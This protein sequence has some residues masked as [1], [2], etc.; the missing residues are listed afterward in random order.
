MVRG[1]FSFLEVNVYGAW[2]FFTLLLLLATLSPLP[3]QD[4]AT[5]SL[6]GEMDAVLNSN[7]VTWAEAARF[8]MPA[9]GMQ[10]EDVASAFEAARARG[11]LPKNAAP[12]T[13]ANFGGLSF[14]MMKAFDIP[15]GLMYRLFPGPHYA[16]RELVYRG[17]I[18]DQQDKSWRVSGF[19]LI[20]LIGRVLETSGLE[21]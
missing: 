5:A 7:A 1:L 21:E 18:Q 2:H 20:S 15:G 3:A 6:A 8:V 19:W 17:V 9:A 13:L 11:W 16:Y 14:L 12:D 10:A 4:A